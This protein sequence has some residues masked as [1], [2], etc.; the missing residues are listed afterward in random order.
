MIKVAVLSVAAFGFSLTGMA[1]PICITDTLSNYV[2]LSSGGCMVGTAT[3]ANFSS[4]GV[5]TGSTQIPLSSIQVTPLN[6][7][8]SPGLQF[9]LN[10]NAR[11][12]GAQDAVFG[13]NVTAASITGASLT[14]TGFSATGNGAATAAKNLCLGGNFAPGMIAGCSTGAT[15]ALSNV[16]IAGALPFSQLTDSTMFSSVSSLGVVDNIAADPGGTGTAAIAGT[17]T[18]SFTATGARAAVPEPATML[19]FATGF[20]GVVFLRRRVVG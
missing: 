17:V 16:V 5:P 9:G 8:G 2:A 13:F 4:L 20:C 14:S 12:G 1:A 18:N 11:S 3:V 6:V 7:A 10:V 15:R 19:L